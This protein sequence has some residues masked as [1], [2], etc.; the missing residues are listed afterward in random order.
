[1]NRMNRMN[2]MNAVSCCHE[3]AANKMAEF[4]CRLIQ[5]GCQRGDV[6]IIL[7]NPCHSRL[8]KF[9]PLRKLLSLVL[10][11]FLVMLLHFVCICTYIEPFWSICVFP[12]L[13]PATSCASCLLLLV[14]CASSL[15]L[16]PG[17]STWAQSVFDIHDV[18]DIF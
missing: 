4:C 16:C 11:A 10:N 12:P 3:Q 8:W 1:M 6:V 2:R 9:P 7:E 15:L 17:C 5:L 14:A 13:C 18:N